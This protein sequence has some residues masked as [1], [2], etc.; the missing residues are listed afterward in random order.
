ML[1]EFITHPDTIGK[2][3]LLVDGRYFGLPMEV[4]LRFQQLQKLAADVIEL[5]ETGYLPNGDSTDVQTM[6]WAE[7]W[8]SK[9]T[10]SNQA[11]R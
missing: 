10:L 8:A 5:Y 9:L 4:I 6:L 7:E 3:R 1:I 11:H 2:G